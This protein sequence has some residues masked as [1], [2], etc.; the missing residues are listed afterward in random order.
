MNPTRHWNRFLPSL[1]VASSLAMAA[2]VNAATILNSSTFDGTEPETDGNVSGF[3]N[4]GGTTFDTVNGWTW[5]TVN[6]TGSGGNGVFSG[7]TGSTI[8]DQ[9][10]RVG[11]SLEL[12]T[13]NGGDF[14]FGWGGS[15]NIIA[16]A[17][18]FTV[19]PGDTVT[20][21]YD[22]TSSQGG[23]YLYVDQGNGTYISRDFAMANGSGLSDSFTATGTNIRIAVVGNDGGDSNAVLQDIT[24]QSVPEPGAWVSL[25]GGCGVLLGL[26][27]RRY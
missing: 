18:A 12:E 6:A 11:S 10:I 7:L 21:K 2:S 23:M 1:V 19:N 25:L 24:V 9:G 15:N 14:N 3:Y 27:R 26:S 17:Q 8:R 13:G 5:G 20:V 4:P 22:L 16:L